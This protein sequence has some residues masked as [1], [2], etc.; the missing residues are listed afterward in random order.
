MRDS[1]SAGKVYSAEF[2]D[3]PISKKKKSLVN[4]AFCS[5]GTSTKNYGV[6]TAQ[7]RMP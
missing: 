7:P 2:V 5:L 1:D 6:N 4:E 3:R